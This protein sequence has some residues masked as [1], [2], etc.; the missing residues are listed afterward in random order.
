MMRRNVGAEEQQWIHASREWMMALN[1]I[2]VADLLNEMDF[3]ENITIDN[4]LQVIL[5]AQEKV[6]Q[7]LNK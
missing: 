6:Q 4:S 2:A 7:I 1:Q 5:D 3:E